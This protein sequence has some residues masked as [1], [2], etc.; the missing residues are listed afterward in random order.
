VNLTK[1]VLR[2][3]S[4]GEWH[5]L[6][7]VIAELGPAIPPEAATQKYLAA[8]KKQSLDM[9]LDEQV[10]SGRRFL[11]AR[12][13]HN[14]CASERAEE[15]HP[16]MGGLGRRFKLCVREDGRA[17]RLLVE[18]DMVYSARLRGPDFQDALF[19]VRALRRIGE[20]AAE[21]KGKRKCKEAK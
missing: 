18:L 16:S 1:D 21:A 3:L 14:L 6:G 11:I 15:Q 2:A 13:L 12:A 8:R 9:P 17:G 19:H 4:D 5:T 20:G 7:E 10:R